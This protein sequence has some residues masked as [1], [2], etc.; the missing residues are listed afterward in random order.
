MAAKIG[1]KI[2]TQNSDIGSLTLNS[3]I[4]MSI[5]VIIVGFEFLVRAYRLQYDISSNP[6]QPW[7][8]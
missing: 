3:C 8:I 5:I 7:T 6:V 4:L 1:I 2:L